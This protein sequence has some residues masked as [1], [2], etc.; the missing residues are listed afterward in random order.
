MSTPR[1]DLVD[2][3]QTLRNRRKILVIVTVVAAILGGLLFFVRKK[4]YKAEAN[5][6]I[7]NPL[8]ADRTNIFRTTDMNF[9]DYFGGD[10]DI[11]RIIA[12]ATSDTVRN[13]V[14]DKLNLWD[15]YKLKKDDPEDRDKMRGIFKKNY[16]IKRTEF[17]TAKVTYIDKDPERVAQVVNISMEI[18]EEVFRSYYIS[19]KNNVGFSIQRKITELDS[20]IAALTDTLGHLR[21]KYKIYDIVNPAR[22]N[23]MTAQVRP[24]GGAGFGMALEKLQNIEAVKDQLVKDKASSMSV[25][26]EFQTGADMES[27]EYIHVITPGRAPVDPTGLGLILTVLAMGLLGFFFCSVYVLISTYY[28]VLI[29]VER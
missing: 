1:F 14:A 10:D 6:I 2:V 12:V 28:K 22:A 17:T 21:D 13:T 29:A 24:T 23:L 8:Y 3:T 15:A 4:K 26:N 18:M 27:M 11:D 16:K 5:F 25:L 7:A 9:V 19:M 20:S